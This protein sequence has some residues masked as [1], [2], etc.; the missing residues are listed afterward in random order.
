MMTEARQVNGG[1]EK[2]G[3]ASRSWECCASFFLGMDF[4]QN[5]KITWSVWT[6]AA[7]L[8]FGIGF[9]L[10]NKFGRDLHPPDFEES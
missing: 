2:G 8:L 7:V 1:G 10:L 3:T 4:L 9:A 5:G 6:V